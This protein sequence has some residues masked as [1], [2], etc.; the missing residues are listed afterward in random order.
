MRFPRTSSSRPGRTRA[1]A[2]AGG[3]PFHAERVVWAKKIFA[4]YEAGDLDA[5]YLR[6]LAHNNVQTAGDAITDANAVT[7]TASFVN[8]WAGVA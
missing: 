6:F 5:E 2:E 3:T 7:A 4:N 8:E 1:S